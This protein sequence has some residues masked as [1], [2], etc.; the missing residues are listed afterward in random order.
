MKNDSYREKLLG[1]LNRMRTQNVMCD[2]L[3]IVGERLEFKVYKTI[4]VASSDYFRAMLMGGMRESKEEKAELKGL[5]SDGLEA[6]INYAYTGSFCV[7]VDNLDEILQA[8]THLQ[9]P[10]AVDSCCEFMEGAN[11]VENCVDMLKLTEVYSL[12]VS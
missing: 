2:Y 12:N 8:A 3:L 11:S 7:T 9:M 6:M 1:N 5:T 4:M 10:E